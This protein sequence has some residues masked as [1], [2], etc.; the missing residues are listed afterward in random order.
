MR[1]SAMQQS[2]L[3]AQAAAWAV[4]H[5]DG[6]PLTQADLA[7]GHQ[8]GPVAD[9]LAYEIASGSMTRICRQRP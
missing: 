9:A 8:R 2:P 6:L 1:L 7:V 4:A 3:N 5:L